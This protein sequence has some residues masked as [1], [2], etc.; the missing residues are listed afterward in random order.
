MCSCRTQCIIPWQTRF[1]SA[2]DCAED[3]V[4][5]EH[6]HWRIAQRTCLRP[7]DGISGGSRIS[8]VLST[9]VDPA[10]GGGGARN[11]KSIRPPSVAIFFMTYFTGPGGAWPPIPPDPLLKALLHTC[12]SVFNVYGAAFQSLAVPGGIPGARILHLWPN[13]RDPTGTFAFLFLT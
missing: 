9:V 3:K 7:M 2:D 6:R 10:A 12:P 1:T 13:N 5:A 8:Q 4:T 11:M